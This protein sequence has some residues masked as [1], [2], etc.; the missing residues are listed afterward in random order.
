[1]KKT[2]HIPNQ[3]INKLRKVETARANGPTIADAVRNI[4]VT[5]QTYYRWKHKCGMM[6]REQLQ[7]QGPR[8][9]EQ[10]TQEACRR[11]LPRQG[12]SY[13]GA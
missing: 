6:D 7:R 1:M 3:I 2:R 12:Y 10:A 13:G 8:E 5:E 9:G 4:G 11:S